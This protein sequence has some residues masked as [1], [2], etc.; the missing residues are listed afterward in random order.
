MEDQN[1]KSNI[2]EEYVT[3]VQD[4][5]VTDYI[6]NL[7]ISPEKSKYI[8]ACFLVVLAIICLILSFVGA[9]NLTIGGANIAS[10]GRSTI[11]KAYYAELKLIYN[12]FANFIRAFGIF[13]AGIF[14]WLG[15][16]EIS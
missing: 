16:K 7:E 6:S 12:G 10:I 4:A 15:L 14:L 1:R 3:S 13:S 2:T 8:K 11:E 9:S 5:I